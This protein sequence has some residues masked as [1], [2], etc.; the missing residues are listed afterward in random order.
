MR[1]LVT[2]GAGFIGRNLVE[3]LRADG[4]GVRV[5]DDLSSGAP[6]LPGAVTAAAG[7]AWRAPLEFVRGDIRDLTA[8]RAACRGA[9]AVVHLAATAG[10]ADSLAHPVE[11]CENNA[12]GTLIVLEA[13]RQEGVRR[14]VVAS[15]GAAVGEVPP[16]VR[17]DAVPAPVS[18]YGASKLAAEAYCHAYRASFGLGALALRF[19]NVYGP[20]SGHKT[21]AVATFIAALLDGGV[22]T[23]HGDGEQTRDF[24]FVGD[25]VDGIVHAVTTP[26]P[27][28]ALYQLGS[29]VET[30]VNALVGLLGDLALAR[31]GARPRVEHRPAR[32]GEVRRSVTD[33]TRAARDL[34]W[35]PRT[36]LAAGLALTFD[37]FVARRAA[38]HPPGAR[39]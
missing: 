31:L 36:P 12:T 20:H 9:D 28:H 22:L 34:A 10:I 6:P 17:E 19:S 37:W 39:G 26:A 3:R 7:G 18:P 25:L 32:A 33:V 38:A 2:G 30:S 35:V 11:H 16:P 13:C 24:V 21:S 5:L 29:G 27:A 15:S 4:L 8:T 23:V 14:C 1:I